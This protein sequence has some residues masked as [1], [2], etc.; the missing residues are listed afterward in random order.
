MYRNA[1]ENV[2]KRKKLGGDSDKAGS[3]KHYKIIIKNW[4]VREKTH[5]LKKI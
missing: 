5:T 1:G 3:R 2:K 4:K